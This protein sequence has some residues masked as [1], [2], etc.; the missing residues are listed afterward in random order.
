MVKTA[1]AKFVLIF[2]AAPRA[3]YEVS[4]VAKVLVHSKLLDAV[5]SALCMVDCTLDE[6]SSEYVSRKS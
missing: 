3:K 1:S 2:A 4:C 5:S 6:S